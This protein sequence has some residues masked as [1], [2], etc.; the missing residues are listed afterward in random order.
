MENML[1]MHTGGWIGDM[2]LL[3]PALR[4]LKSKFPNCP[5]AMLILPLVSELMSRNPYINE[6]ITYDKNKS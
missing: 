2:I 4:N 3:T 1:I 5:I 6:I